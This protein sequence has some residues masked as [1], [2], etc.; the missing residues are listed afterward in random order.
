MGF[1][2]SHLPLETLVSDTI[3]DTNNLGNKVKALEEYF[4]TI[5]EEV[6]DVFKVKIKDIPNFYSIDEV[7]EKYLPYVAYL[8]GYI[9]DFSLSVDYQKYILRTIV[10]VYKRKGT[11][12]SIRYGLDYFDFNSTI[13]EPYKDIFILNK[14]KFG[15]GKKF[16]SELYYSRGVFIVKTSIDPT[17]V[18]EIVENVRPAGVKLI[19]DYL[20]VEKVSFFK[21]ITSDKYYDYINENFTFI[22]GLID[23]QQ[24]FNLSIEKDSLIYN[25]LSAA[26]F[27]GNNIKEYQHLNNEIQMLSGR[28]KYYLTRDIEFILKPPVYINDGTNSIYLGQT[29]YGTSPFTLDELYTHKIIKPGIK[30]ENIKLVFGESNKIN[31]DLLQI[32][33]DETFFEHSLYKNNVQKSEVFKSVK[34]PL[35]PGKVK[36]ILG[37][38]ILLGRDTAEGDINKHSFSISSFLGVPFW[39]DS[40]KFEKYNDNSLEDLAKMIRAYAPSIYSINKDCRIVKSLSPSDD[41]IFIDHIEN[42]PNKGIAVV[43]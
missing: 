4:N 31:K 10:D 30:K 33:N 1:M 29:C 13:S 7:N 22:P 2:Y 36:S 8:L 18:R 40:S 37:K 28:K 34:G 23:F 39:S 15:E 43:N 24:F 17:L 32:N 42:L 12:F 14:S 9:W 11:K 35:V 5:E 19:I 20:S 26:I 38:R 27:R 25:D 6:F 21:R 3:L 41:E 16:A